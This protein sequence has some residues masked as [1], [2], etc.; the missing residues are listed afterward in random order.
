M[1]FNFFRRKVT[2]ICENRFFQNC[3]GSFQEHSGSFEL[4]K[5]VFEGKMADNKS[6]IFFCAEHMQNFEANS[7]EMTKIAP[8]FKNSGLL[9]K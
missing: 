6:I 9:K 7:M 4:K 5:R 2:K 8:L 1:N 3:S